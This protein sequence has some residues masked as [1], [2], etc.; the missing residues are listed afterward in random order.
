V[1]VISG[2][3]SCFWIS[4]GRPREAILYAVNFGRD[5]DC[6][7]YIAGGLAGALRGIQSIPSDWVKTIEDEVVND[8]YTVSR[9]TAGESAQGLYEACMNVRGQ[10]KETVDMLDSLI[11][12]Q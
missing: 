3:L 4:E 1:E 7:A 11:Y 2:A 10:M 6:R 5:T 9:R 12:S 8:P